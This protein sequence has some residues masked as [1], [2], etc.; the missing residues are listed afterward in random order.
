MHHAIFVSPSL[1][2]PYLPSLFSRFLYLLPPF[3]PITIREFPVPGNTTHRL[4]IP[5][6]TQTT[7]S[8][9]P[10]S[11]SLPPRCP[12]INS[13]LTQNFD[14]PF[15]FV[16]Y[17]LY[18][19]YLHFFLFSSSFSCISMLYCL[20]RVALLTFFHSS[21]GINI[22]DYRVFSFFW[23]VSVHKCLL[24]CGGNGILKLKVQ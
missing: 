12:S 3:S 6:G 8:F 10:H 24:L 17:S 22:C 19:F 20:A 4:M 15:F 21:F 9:S 5:Q 2:S 7:T 14:P 16:I 23:L 11:S 18:I 1:L 13:I